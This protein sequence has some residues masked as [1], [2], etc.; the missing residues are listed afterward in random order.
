M[1]SQ[2]LFLIPKLIR[3]ARQQAGLSQKALAISVGLDQSFLCALEKGRRHVSERK[4]LEAISQA[5]SSNQSKT[6]ELLWAWTHDKVLMETHR[7][8]LPASTQR[9]V[10]ASLHASLL[11]GREEL[12]GLENTIDLA[13]RSKR[14]LSVL[15]GQR[16]AREP[17]VFMT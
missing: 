4:L 13:I 7:A 3:L 1:N 17:E 16:A 2:N 8:G 11:L 9:L 14:A 10:S 5:T 6:D 15:A 12:A